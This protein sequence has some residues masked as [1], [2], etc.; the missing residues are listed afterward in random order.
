MEENIEMTIA[1]PAREAR[2][3]FSTSDLCRVQLV[4]QIQ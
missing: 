2:W 4:A 3:S 1:P